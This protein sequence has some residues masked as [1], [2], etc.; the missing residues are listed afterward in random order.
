[1]P[2]SMALKTSLVIT[3]KDEKVMSVGQRKTNASPQQESKPL[4]H[5]ASALSD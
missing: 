4:E 3:V 5:R 1:M 2:L